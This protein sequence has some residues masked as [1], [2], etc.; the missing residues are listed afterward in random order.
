VLVAAGLDSN[1][2]A[3]VGACRLY[4]DLQEQRVLL[5]DAERRLERELV[6]ARAPRALPGGERDLQERGR[7][8]DRS[9]DDAVLREP[10][11]T[12]RRQAGG[13]DEIVGAR[14]PKDRAEKRVVRGL[15]AS[16]FETC[17]NRPTLQ[18]VTRAL[19]WIGRKV[20]VPGRRQDEFPTGRQAASEERSP[21]CKEPYDGAFVAAEGGNDESSSF[22][23]AFCDRGPENRVRA[24]FDEESVPVVRESSNR[25]LELDGLPEVLEPVRGVELFARDRGSA[26]RGVER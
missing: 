15:E 8:E 4:R 23:E 26:H 13:K 6:D 12:A 24:Y 10:R 5:G 1:D 19:K 18:P 25:A 9:A 17:V 22:S 21:R 7:R 20:D 14:R 16:G 2:A 3:T 11:M